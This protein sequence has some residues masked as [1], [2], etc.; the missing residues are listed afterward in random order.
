MKLSKMLLKDIKGLQ[1]V[2]GMSDDEVIERLERMLKNWGRR[3][4]SCPLQY[5]VRGHSK[6][7]NSLAKMENRTG[8]D[9]W[10]DPFDI[11][12]YYTD[13]TFSFQPHGSRGADWWNELDPLD[14][15]EHIRKLIVYF[16]KTKTPEWKEGMNPEQER[17]VAYHERNL[18]ALEFADGWYDDPDND[19]PGWRRVLSLNS[20]A[21]CFHIP[22]DFPVGNLPK[23][24]PNWDGHTTKEK[25]TRVLKYRGIVEW[26]VEPTS[27]DFEGDD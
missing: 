5:I 4:S 3:S 21:M 20:G 26:S 11:D 23:I 25:W 7:L 18:L 16:K 6:F 9:G 17:D 8:K 22:D 19:W 24:T 14:Q 27:K 1:S 13:Q 15:Q 2:L 12:K 10:G